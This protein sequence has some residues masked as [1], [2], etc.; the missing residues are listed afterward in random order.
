[1]VSFVKTKIGE[2]RGQG[3]EEGEEKEERKTDQKLRRR[4]VGEDVVEEEL[5]WK[6]RE[7]RRSIEEG[8]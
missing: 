4:E 1:M 6:A 5:I 2:N 7:C 8:G 3:G